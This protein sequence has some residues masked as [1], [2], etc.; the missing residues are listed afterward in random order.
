MFSRL[1]RK[2]VFFQASL[3]GI[4]ALTLFFMCVPEVG[5]ALDI[6]VSPSGSNNDETIINNALDAVYNAG[7]GKVYLMSGTYQLT[8]RIN[9]KSGVHLQG[10]SAANTILRAGPN[11]GGSVSGKTTDGWIYCISLTNIEISNLAFTSTAS[12]TD[13][14]G[15]GETRNCILLRG[16]TNVK[17]HD[18]QVIKYVYN[19]F[20]K[21]HTGDNIQVYDNS[22]QCGHDFVEFLSETKNSRAYGNNIVVQTNTGIRCD[23]AS[24]IELDHNTLTGAGGTGWCLMEMENSLS[25]I[26]IHHNIMHDYHGS[27]NSYAV[28]PVTVSGS[29]SVNNNVLW[30][31]GSIAYGTTKDNNIDPSDRSISSWVAKGYGAG[32]SGTV[33][34]SLIPPAV[35]QVVTTPPIV[36]TPS[37]E[38]AGSTMVY[39][40]GSKSDQTV[41]NNALE[42]VHNSGGGKV[43][44]NAGTYTIDNTIVI[45]SN[46]I[47]TGSPDAVIL[48]SPSSSQWFT[49]STGII[50][51]KEPVK[52]VEISGFQINGNLGALPASYANTPGHNKD[53]ER[54]I[55]LHG[56]SGDYA[57]NIK[58]HDMKLY[59]SFSD[60]AYIY[61]AKNVQFYN[62]FV[63]NTQHEGVF[64]SVVIGGEIHNN[65]IAGIT[66]DC[67]RL[68]NCIDCRVYDNIFFSYDGDNTNGAYKHGEN[69]LQ[70]GNAGSSHGYDAS[71]KPT[72]TTNIEIFNNTF[73][74]NGLQ[75]IMLGSGSGNNVFVH[76]N[77][78]IG[79]A[80]L[81][82]MG[83]PVVVMSGNVSY[84]NPPTKEMSEKIF[85]SIFDILNQTFT[86]SGVTNQ[87]TDD[88]HYTVQKT[89][90]GMISGGIKI[91]GFRNIISIDDQSY[92]PDNN[93]TIVK[94]EAVKSLSLNFFGTGIEKMDKKVDVKM[95]NGTSNATLTVTTRYYT[96]STNHITGNKRTNYKTTTATFTDSAPSPN[97]LQRPAEIKGIV[98][99]YPTFFK[100]SVPPSG[101]VKVQYEYDGSSSEHVYMIGERQT[102]KNGVEYT[103]FSSVNYWKGELYHSG[104]M[105][106]VNG[107]FDPEKLTVKAYTPY[108][109]LNVEKVDLIKYE[110]PDKIVADWFFPSIGVMILLGFG[111]RFYMKKLRF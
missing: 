1:S 38:P 101:L 14:G 93:S 107:V 97:V 31:V 70:V 76:D 7:G 4:F 43:Y 51:C 65:Q 30:N 78:F 88:I 94:Y 11:T 91:I 36:T 95:K 105:L 10:E 63:S 42:A 75:A 64:F 60:G 17:I 69:G 77:K 33:A 26:N 85:G 67:A 44:L 20:V 21:C 102:D 111:A 12:G 41:I 48:V 35:P 62:N 80:E 24:N 108:E 104:E 99:Q 84:T 83:I 81:E 59:D 109:T 6:T 50:S 79:K 40:T 45:W 106:Y 49:G 47:L 55:I 82:T 3:K 15:L 46:T 18:N 25:N 2:K 89:D 16:C 57:D 23:G 53:A 61:Y 100:C 19:D 98:H 27:S 34:P 103:N 68:D 5:D 72:V 22:G 92:V 74:N 28:A 86:D 71:N 56:N 32:S 110:A 13:D 39:P 54:C 29:V 73:A 87:T 52:N 9:M 8:G 58:I 90:S 66:S 96:F 37:P